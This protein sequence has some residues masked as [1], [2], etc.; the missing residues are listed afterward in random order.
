MG[1]KNTVTGFKDADRDGPSPMAV[2]QPHAALNVQRLQQ[3]PLQQP[4]HHAPPPPMHPHHLPYMVGQ[5]HHPFP[6]PAQHSRHT[7]Q[8]P[9]PQ[10]TQPRTVHARGGSNGGEPWLAAQNLTF[11]KRGSPS[12]EDGSSAKKSKPAKVP[13]RPLAATEQHEIASMPSLASCSTSE[14]SPVSDHHKYNGNVRKANNKQVKSVVDDTGGGVS[15]LLM[16]AYAMT[17]FAGV[18]AAGGKSRK[19]NGGGRSTATKK[20][21]KKHK[22]TAEEPAVSAGSPSKRTKFSSTGDN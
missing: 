12:S 20:T 18:S 16:A 8:P 11:L 10:Q 13:S 7:S 19:G 17:E 4:H 2:R 15:S 6:S 1:C 22:A 3:L 14:L 5:P 21:G 9:T